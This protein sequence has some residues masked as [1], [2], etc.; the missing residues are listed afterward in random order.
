MT[1]KMIVQIM[2]LLV[3]LGVSAEQYRAAVNNPD[4]SDTELE[5]HIASNSDKLK[6]LQDKAH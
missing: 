3:Q 6:E 4:M 5:D 1:P 2:R